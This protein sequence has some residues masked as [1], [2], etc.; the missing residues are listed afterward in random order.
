MKEST[1]KVF[2]RHGWRVDRAI[3]NC[4]Y[5][6]FYAPYVKAALFLTRI[7]VRL[8]SGFEPAN[9]LTRFIF[10]RYHGKVLSHGDIRKIITLEEDV[11]LGSD[12]SIVPF[13]YAS[14]I[15]LRQPGDMAV[16]ECP[17]K[18]TLKEPCQ[19]VTACIAI[20]QPLVDFWLEHCRKYKA[21]RITPEEAFEIIDAHRR[22]GHINQAFF[23]VATG[24]SIGVL[25]NCCP[26]CCVSLRATAMAK[27]IKGG[28]SV[29]QYAPS[30]YA[31]RHD[32][33]RCELCGR[34][35]EICNFG[36]VALRDGERVYDSG[37]CVGCELCVEGCDRGALFLTLGDGPLLP[38]DMDMVKG[39]GL[40]GRAE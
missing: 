21:R 40:T 34:C 3:H 36:A 29:S 19:P 7:V 12:T 26:K 23:K 22:T 24:G 37:A 14:K 28:E 38:L 31:V 30:G 33:S 11:D 9:H 13:K 35:A 2:R 16:M 20:G 15:L 25:C 27:R 5:F 1:R 6:I 32:P 4:L 17:C 8:F 18:L 39:A 10:N